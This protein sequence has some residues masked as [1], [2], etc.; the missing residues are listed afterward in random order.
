VPA[1]S[2]PA[3]QSGGWATV[4]LLFFFM[5]IDFAEIARFAATPRLKGALAE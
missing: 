1:T 2:G 4:A 3:A 5:M